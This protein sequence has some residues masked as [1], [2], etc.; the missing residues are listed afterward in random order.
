MSTQRP[1]SNVDHYYNQPMSSKDLLASLEQHVPFGV[2]K[3]S[4][5]KISNWLSS[6]PQFDVV[7]KVNRFYLCRQCRRRNIQL[8]IEYIRHDNSV[9]IGNV[10]KSNGVGNR[11]KA[12]GSSAEDGSSSRKNILPKSFRQ[13]L[14]IHWWNVTKQLKP[15]MQAIIQKFRHINGAAKASWR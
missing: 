11:R 8:S 10:R 1:T 3:C 5:Q 12:S 9:D 14:T 4:A 15:S 2:N 7:K 13:M 6:L